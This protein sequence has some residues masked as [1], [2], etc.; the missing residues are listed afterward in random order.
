M[1]DKYKYGYLGQERQDELGLNWHTYRYRNADPALGRFFGIDP[2]SEEYMSISTYQFAHNNPVWKIEIEGLEGQ[3]TSG[4]DVVN[5]EPVGIKGEFGIG[6]GKRVGLSINVLGIELSGVYDRG[7]ARFEVELGVNENG[8]IIGDANAV[9][10]EGY[11]LSTPFYGEKQETKIKYKDYSSEKEGSLTTVV[12]EQN[13][14]AEKESVSGYNVGNVNIENKV[15]EQGSFKVEEYKSTSSKNVVHH[16][17]TSTGSFKGSGNKTKSQNGSI[18]L[19][20]ISANAGISVD[21]AVKVEGGTNNPNPYSQSPGY[22]GSRCFIEGTGILM[23]S[24]EQKVIEQIKVG[25]VIKTYNFNTKMIENKKVLHID[26]PIHYHFVKM[27]FSNNVINVNTEDHPYYVKG[28]GWAS[29][30]PHLTKSNYNLDVKKIEINDDVYFYDDKEGS[31]INIKLIKL[32]KINKK[33]RT[34]NLSEVEDNHNFFA[35]KILV[36]NKF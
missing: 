13:V 24:G 27:Y 33:L 18:T 25:D 1:T 2:V 8:D 22:Y 21:A 14:N 32:E 16:V 7:S 6:F 20:G 23:E 5:N 11:E 19:F 35:N 29:F 30:N 17:N 31:L 3:E 34:Y 9:Y 12:P 26:N 36:H 10:T 15:S 4:N 28:K